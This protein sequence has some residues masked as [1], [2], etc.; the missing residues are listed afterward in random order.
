M[1]IIK[2]TYINRATNPDG[3]QNV[4]GYYGPDKGWLPMGTLQPQ[5]TNHVPEQPASFAKKLLQARIDAQRS[6]T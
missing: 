3:S 4:A 6:T 2:S 5:I 1:R